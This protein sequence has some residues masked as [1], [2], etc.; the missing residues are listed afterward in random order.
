MQKEFKNIISLFS[1]DET[2][3]NKIIVSAFIKSNG[4][5]V[6]N[7]TLIKSLIISDN[8]GL[9]QYTQLDAKFTFDDL[10][11]AFELAIPKKEQVVNGAV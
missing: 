11:E 4:I 9:N 7:N 1:E 8:S 5:K 6:R 3:L 2:S 10:I